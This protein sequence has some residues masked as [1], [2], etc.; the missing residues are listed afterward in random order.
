MRHL[1]LNEFPLVTVILLVFVVV[2]VDQDG[3]PWLLLLL[4]GLV[5]HAHC[6]SIDVFLLMLLLLTFI[7][8]VVVA[9]LG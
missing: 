6:G 8:R 2:M 5:V 4:Y 3:L 9:V 7:T 1:F